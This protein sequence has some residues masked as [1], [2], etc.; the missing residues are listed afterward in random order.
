MTPAIFMSSEETSFG[1]KLSQAANVLYVAHFIFLYGEDQRDAKG[2]ARQVP[3]K[4]CHSL[5]G[6]TDLAWAPCSSQKSEIYDGFLKPTL[7]PLFGD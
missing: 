4:I 5:G 1:T 3:S 7:Q 2:A 6:G